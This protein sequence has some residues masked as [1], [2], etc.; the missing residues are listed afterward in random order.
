MLPKQVIPFPNGLD[1][2]AYVLGVTEDFD[3][4]AQAEAEVIN[5]I[6]QPAMRR[7]AA[8]VPEGE[9]WG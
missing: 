6:R 4:L 3:D 7:I 8:M 2:N 5:Q 9:Q 1:Y